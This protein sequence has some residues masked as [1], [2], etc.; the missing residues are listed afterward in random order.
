[1]LKTKV[2][3]ILSILFISAVPLAASNAVFNVVKLGAKPDGKTDSTKSFIEAWAGACGSSDSST[4]N[5]PSGRYLIRNG[6][7][8]GPCKNA[9]I[10]IRIEGTLIAP[11]DYNVIGNS[12][13][14]LSFQWITGV[15][16]YGGT[17][18]GQGIGLWACKLGNKKCPDGATSLS[19]TNSKDIV[20]NGLKSLN[21]QMFHIVINRCENVN[22]RGL[23]ITA[24]GNS[25][26]T[27]GIHVQLSTGVTIMNSGIKTGDDCISIGPGT[28]NLWIEH[29]ACGPG[30]GISIGSLAKNLDEP[31]VQ[32]VTVKTVVFTGTQNGLRIKAW[33]RP[34]NGFVKGV[35]FQHVLMKNVQNPIIIDQ[36]YCPR[37]EGCPNQS[38]RGDCPG[39][40]SV[41]LDMISAIYVSGVKI[42]H[43]TFQDIQGTS[44]TKVAVKLDCSPK[45]PC[46]GI[47]LENVKLRYNNQ[48]AVSSCS[49]ADGSIHGVVEPAGCL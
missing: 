7:F 36:N 46:E 27:D 45:N 2:C 39:L 16:I 26:N 43:I 1:M 24:S 23:M 49:N 25:P 42:S 6:V 14:W 47:N 17:L 28:K 44:A 20:I 13:N 21:A 11:S 34:S 30:H 32:N 22:M 37:D 18:D 12:E 38:R 19:F 15:S 5:V 33:G 41:G 3:I 8:K 4:I 40:K 31:G 48:P 29:I 10:T 9:D 35:V